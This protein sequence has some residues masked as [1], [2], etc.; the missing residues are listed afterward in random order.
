MNECEI[1]GCEET[2]LVSACN[3]CEGGFC[4]EHRLPENH[5]CP[6][7]KIARSHGPDFRTTASESGQVQIGNVQ[8]TT[9]DKICASDNCSTHVAPSKDYCRSCRSKRRVQKSVPS[10]PDLT[11]EGKL[12][13]DDADRDLEPS[14]SSGTLSGL[15]SISFS[16]LWIRFRSQVRL[17][18]RFGSIVLFLLG[19]Y[20]MATSAPVSGFVLMMVGIGLA[21]R[22][23]ISDRRIRYHRKT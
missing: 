15:G 17:L 16:S 5:S 23:I 13:Y 22:W 11:A 20:I 3:Y 10:G 8:Q 19:L 12:D 9:N 14:G 4:S 18:L 1:D 6:Q 7:V 21:Y 2:E